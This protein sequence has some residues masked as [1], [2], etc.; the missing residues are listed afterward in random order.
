MQYI[1][2]LIWQFF[3]DMNLNGM[4]WSKS[5]K[6]KSQLCL[7]P[8]CYFVKAPD[9]GSAEDKILQSHEIKVRENDLLY[10]K[11]AMNVYVQN[12]HLTT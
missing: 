10:P 11:Q 1:A 4:N 2:Q 3:F 9:A 6:E 12:I 8:E 7:S 5:K